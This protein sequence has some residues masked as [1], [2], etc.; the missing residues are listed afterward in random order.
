RRECGGG[1]RLSRAAPQEASLMPAPPT[2]CPYC[3]VPLSAA[4]PR[5]PASCPD[6]GYV[7]P[8]APA[9]AAP[10]GG[11]T[12]RIDAPKPPTQPVAAPPADA[13]Y[14]ARGKDRYGPVPLAEL[15]RLAHAGHLTPADM[16]LPAGAKQWVAAGSV[17]G[18]TPVAAAPRTPSRPAPAP[19]LPG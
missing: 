12:P 10:V 3:N 13:W 4:A 15:P 9:N 11:P 1:G 7:P 16:V 8:G 18:L 6:C 17:E 2:A 14:Y 19:A 5:K